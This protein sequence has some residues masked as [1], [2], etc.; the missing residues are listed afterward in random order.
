MHE[1]V[2]RKRALQKIATLM[3]QQIQG[4]WRQLSAIL[5]SCMENL[6]FFKI[7]SFAIG[8]KKG[9]AQNRHFPGTGNFGYLK[10]LNC[11]FEARNWT[12]EP[13]QTRIQPHLIFCQLDFIWRFHGTLLRWSFVQFLFKHSH[14]SNLRWPQNLA[15]NATGTG[16]SSQLQQYLTTQPYTLQVRFPLLWIKAYPSLSQCRVVYRWNCLHVPKGFGISHRLKSCAPKQKYIIFFGALEINISTMWY[17]LMVWVSSVPFSDDD[18]SCDHGDHESDPSERQGHVH[19]RVVA[20]VLATH[21][22]AHWVALQSGMKTMNN[23]SAVTC[24]QILKWARQKS[25]ICLEGK[26]MT[27]NWGK[28]ILF[29][30]FFWQWPFRWPWRLWE[31]PQQTTGSFMYTIVL[32]LPSLTPSILRTE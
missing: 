3:E 5:R 24:N 6:D 23:F 18:H 4:T 2:N 14:P 32:L 17:Y 28:T 15:N 10:A 26:S 29:C 27:P 9:L 22:L 11:H 7:E 13:F 12:F 8:L 20:A 21:D 1:M 19:R 16:T 25:W 30:S 31:Q